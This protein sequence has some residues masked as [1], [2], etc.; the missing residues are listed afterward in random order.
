MALGSP[1]TDAAF[2][3][4]AVR[5]PHKEMDVMCAWFSIRKAFCYAMK[6]RLLP[7]FVG[8]VVLCYFIVMQSLM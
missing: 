2:P 3:T 1:S 5:H 6:M 7:D 4:T 8:L